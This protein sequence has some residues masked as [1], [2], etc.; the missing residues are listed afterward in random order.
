MICVHT[1]DGD[2]YQFDDVADALPWIEGIIESNEGK[3]LTITVY[4][5]ATEDDQ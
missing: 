4:I 5:N 2:Q 3:E 1:D